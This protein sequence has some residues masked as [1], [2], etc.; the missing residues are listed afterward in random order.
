M[1]NNICPI[2]N[3]EFKPYNGTWQ[4]YCS[5]EC[6]KINYKKYMKIYNQINQQ[7]IEKRVRV[8]YEKNKNKIIKYHKNWYIKNK[9]QLNLQHKKYDQ[10]NKE[11]IALRKKNYYESNKEKII[12]QQKK[13]YKIN[14][15]KKIKQQRIYIN[16]KLKTDINFKIKCYLRNRIKS[17]IKRNAKRGHTLD[18][19]GCSIKFLIKYLELRF[20]KDM[21]WHNYGLYGWHIDHIIPCASFDLSKPEEQRKCFHYTNLQPL[22]AFDNL[23]K[24]DKIIKP[25]RKE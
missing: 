2:C 15:T 7:K 14:K 16:N 3:K 22:W 8:W 20:M 18:L 24:N 21:S 23:S 13:Y 9:K 5:K 12:S 6:R 19:L 10:L 1:A 25:Q 4:K 11:K 17:A